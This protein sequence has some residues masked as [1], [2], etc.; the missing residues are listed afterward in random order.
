MRTF[1]SFS[2]LYLWLLQL[3]P[4]TGSDFN[5]Q[6]QAANTYHPNTHVNQY[7]N[8]AQ[9]GQIMH[10]SQQVAYSPGH[11]S[12][13]AIDDIERSQVLQYVLDILSKATAE[14]DTV[15]KRHKTLSVH[16]KCFFDEDSTSIKSL[17]IFFEQLQSPSFKVRNLTIIMALVYMDKVS[18][19]LHLYAS[20]RSARRLFA[21]CL[22]IASKMHENEVSR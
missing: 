5:H 2:F 12:F 1:V 9:S 11:F 16:D 7:Q 20:S 8:P 4:V 14:N 15:N 17:K 13:R 18:Q 3:S 19:I 21:A 10:Y 22:I 6:Y